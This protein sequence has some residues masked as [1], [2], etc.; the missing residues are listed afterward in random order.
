MVEFASGKR[1]IELRG[2]KARP[3]IALLQSDRFGG[4]PVRS[5]AIADIANLAL[6]YDM[7]ERV[8]R[9]FKRRERVGAVDEVEV[10]PIGCEPR[11]A[12]IDTEEDVTARQADAAYFWCCPQPDLAGDDDPIAAASEQSP[13]DPL[14]GAI[15]IIVG[16]I[17]D[18]DTLVDRAVEHSCGVSLA[19]K[20]EAIIA[21]RRCAEIWRSKAETRN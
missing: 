17:D 4:K 7:V 13:Q 6:A 2:R 8:Q 1:I 5:V 21:R 10:D 20:A 12:F 16:G 19:K 3:T 9:L 18:V 15:A 11:Q 14:A